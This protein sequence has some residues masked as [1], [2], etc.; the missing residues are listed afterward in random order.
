MPVY[1]WCVLC[2]IRPTPLFICYSDQISCLA[3]PRLRWFVAGLSPRRPAFDPRSCG[4]CG[5]HSGA[6]TGFSPST[7]VFPVIIF[8]PMLLTYLTE[9]QTG[10]V[11][12]TFQ[13]VMLRRKSESTGQKSK[14]VRRRLLIAVAWFR[15]SACHYGICV[16]WSVIRRCIFPSISVVY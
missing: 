15:V 11:W 13:T 8:L 2:E 4:I 12:G 14:A 7:S 1:L 3:M 9:G 5:G 10:E 6:E 16:R